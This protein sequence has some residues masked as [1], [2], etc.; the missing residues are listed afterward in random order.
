MLSLTQ[1][2]IGV[3]TSHLLGESLEIPINL[4]TWGWLRSAVIIATMVPIS[5][6]GIGIREGA[7]LYLLKPYGVLGEESLAF[8]LLVFAVGVLLSALVGGVL[9]AKTILFPS[10]SRGRG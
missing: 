4:V 2:L 9:E 8:S 5:V 3:L 10:M 6:A 1:H 7:L